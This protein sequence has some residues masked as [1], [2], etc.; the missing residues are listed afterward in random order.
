LTKFYFDSWDAEVKSLLYNNCTRQEYIN[1]A[2][3]PA[4]DGSKAQGYCVRTWSSI[5]VV[6]ILSWSYRTNESPAPYSR[7]YTL[8]CKL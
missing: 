2:Y 4:Y 8:W 3:T 7:C 5:S 6:R 1:F